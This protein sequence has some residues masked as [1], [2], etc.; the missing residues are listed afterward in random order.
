GPA[1]AGLV[2]AKFGAGGAFLFNAVTFLLVIA[3]LLAVRPRPTAPP[4]MTRWVEQFRDGLDYVREREALVVPVVTIFAVALLGSSVVQ[5]AP[6]FARDQ[7]GVGKGAYGILVAAFGTGAIIGSVIMSAYG[8]RVRRSRM[9]IVG[10]VML[11][12]GVLLLAVAVSYAAG[13]VA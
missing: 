5:L 12:G 13:L 4:V 2:L 10:L 6:A 11:A 9:A 8:D 1:L 7:F 3:V